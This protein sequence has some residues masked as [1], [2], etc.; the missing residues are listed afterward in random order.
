MTFQE[1]LFF[2]LG[3]HGTIFHVFIISVILFDLI[4][5]NCNSKSGSPFKEFTSIVSAEQ[6]QT[7]LIFR[8]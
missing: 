5:T 4:G 8:T 7:T 2:D 3:Q 1:P 6:R